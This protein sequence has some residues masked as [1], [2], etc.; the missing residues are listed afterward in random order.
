MWQENNTKPLALLNHCTPHT[1]QFIYLKLDLQASLYSC[2]QVL[3]IGDLWY[4]H[5]LL[6]LLLTNN[7]YLHSAL[8]PNSWCVWKTLC[9]DKN[10]FF[11]FLQ[12]VKAFVVLSAPF[13]SSNPEQLTLELQDHVKKSTAPYKYPRKASIV[14]QS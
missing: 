14:P 2:I 6:K 1:L 11:F 10:W 7:K 13:K 12:V 9:I 4:L 3:F 5:S 8:V